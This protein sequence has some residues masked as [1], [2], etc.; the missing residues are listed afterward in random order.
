MH[1]S[2]K[3]TNCLA[4]KNVWV[5]RWL[6]GLLFLF[7]FQTHCWGASALLFSSYLF[8]T[9]APVSFGSV[10]A[11]RLSPD[12]VWTLHLQLDIFPSNAWVRWCPPSAARGQGH[13]VRSWSWKPSPSAGWVVQAIKGQGCGEACSTQPSSSPPSSEGPL[14]FI[15]HLASGYQVLTL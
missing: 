5:F 4:S 13:L 3:E 10:M 1:R 12:S 2:L 15:A 11:Q 7:W 14:L 9:A 6:L 8:I